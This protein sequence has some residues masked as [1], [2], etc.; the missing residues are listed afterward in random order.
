MKPTGGNQMT[1][2]FNKASEKKKR[3]ELR[4]NMPPAEVM[5]WSKI[6]AKQLDG[7][8]FRRQYSV[9]R[10]I[11][12]F[13]CPKAK[14]GIEIDGDSHFSELAQRYDRKRED[15]IESLGIKILR[16]NNREIYEH[17]DSIWE[18]I[19]NHLP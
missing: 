17:L 13:Y 9:D 6:R 8:K 5:L 7:Y 18:I 16:F 4:K 1:K 19:R 10:Y 2:I 11:L 14:L 3:K 15:F 12:D